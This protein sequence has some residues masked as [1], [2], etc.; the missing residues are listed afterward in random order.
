[1]T[2]KQILNDKEKSDL[3]GD[4]VEHGGDPADKQLIT[5]LVSGKLEA[6]DFNRLE[7]LRGGLSEKI[8][9]ADKIKS[10][11]TPELAMELAKGNPDLEKIVK[12]VSPEGVVKAVHETIKK[13]AVNDPDNFDKISSQVKTIKSFK[14][15]DLKK[16]D[17]KIKEKCDKEGIDADEY[18][19][20]LA[21][22]DNKERTKALQDMV[23][24]QWSGFKRLRNWLSGE[25]ILDK[26]VKNLKK[27]KKEIDDAFID[28]DQHKKNL[29]SILV[30]SVAGN[31]DLL[32]AL[33]REIVGTPKKKEAAPGMND[34]NKVAP[35]AEGI[36]K[37]WDIIKKKER[38]NWSSMTPA[39]QN[40]FRDHFM[41]EQE[42]Y[43]KKSLAEK[44]GFWAAIFGALFDTMFAGFD[45]KSLN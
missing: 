17:D 45:K 4:M 18:M 1:L 19:K 7:E 9:E 36:K 15:G 12:S 8:C 24:G 37:N 39:D 26:S 3:L 42:S 35:D 33:S 16:L 21:I 10:E 34:V 29:G 27:S 20:I 28:L 32:E 13:M 38:P 6:A 25:S 14:E 22:S 23:K 41:K 5:R 11:L 2:V 43:A 30:G 44:G 31:K 40:T